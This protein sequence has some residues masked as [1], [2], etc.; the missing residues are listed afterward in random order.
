[1][2]VQIFKVKETYSFIARVAKSRSHYHVTIP[3]QIGEKLYGANVQV[4]IAVIEIKNKNK[5]G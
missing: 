3:K 5:V 2:S 1:M 4:T